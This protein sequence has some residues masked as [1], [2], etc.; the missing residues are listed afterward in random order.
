M[1]KVL[2]S[3]QLE[4]YAEYIDKKA[5]EA[6]REE[7]IN[8]FES[9]PRCTLAVLSLYDMR[10]PGRPSDRV[11]LYLDHEDLLFLCDSAQGIFRLQSLVDSADTNE[12][13]LWSFFR[14]LLREDV[15]ELADLESE[16]TDAELA[17]MVR[18][19]ENDL[20]RIFLYRKQLLRLKRYY[21]QLDTLL[22]GLAINENG[23][24]TEEGVRYCQILDRRV[25]RYRESVQNLR[26]YVTH[27]REA[28][29]AQLELEQN[30]LMRIFTVVTSVFLPLSLMVGWY[31]MNFSNM[32]ELALPW[33]YPAF[34]VASVLVCGGMLLLFKKKCWI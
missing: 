17:A 11:V 30:N 25:E 16:I 27:T 29:Q 5:L 8:I 7:H 6:I 3:S 4:D 31:G 1:Q 19:R 2:H 14:K 13:A 21:E 22:D 24:L 28:Y 34:I 10:R 18:Y 32:P 15:D 20:Q 23:L 12:Q 33:A 9:F 26:E